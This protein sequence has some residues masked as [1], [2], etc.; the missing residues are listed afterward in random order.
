MSKTK[1]EKYDRVEEEN[2]LGPRQRL[3]SI[4]TSFS[5]SNVEKVVNATSVAQLQ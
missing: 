5:F 1:V 3:F 2:A 4:E